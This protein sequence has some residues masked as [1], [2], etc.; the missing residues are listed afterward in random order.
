MEHHTQRI[1][2]GFQQ[3]F[4]GHSP[5]AEHIVTVKHGLIVHIHVGECVEP[6]ENQI[7]VF[8]RNHRRISIKSRAVFPVREANPLQAR[9]VILVKRIGDEIVVQ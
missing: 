3:A 8:V 9:V 7:N 6:F 4:C 1:R 2:S 5:A